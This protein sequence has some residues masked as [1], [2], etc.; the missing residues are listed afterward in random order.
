MSSSVRRASQ[1]TQL[2]AW[3]HLTWR[4]EVRRICSH[5]MIRSNCKVQLILR[6]HS[7]VIGDLQLFKCTLQ[8]FKGNAVA[9]ILRPWKWKM[10]IIK[11]GAAVFSFF[12][13]KYVW[14][15]YRGK[16]INCTVVQKSLGKTTCKLLLGA[17]FAPC[18]RYFATKSMIHLSF[19]DLWLLRCPAGGVWGAKPLVFHRLLR[20]Q[21]SC[22]RSLPGLINKCAGGWFHWP[23]KQ[24]EP[25]LPWTLIQCQPQLDNREHPQAHWQRYGLH[26]AGGGVSL[27]CCAEWC[28]SDLWILF[29]GTC[30]NHHFCFS[31]VHLY[32]VGGEVYAECL[33]DT[34]I[35]VQSRNCNY[36]HGFHPTTVCKIPSGCSLKIFNNQE[37]AQLLAQS[38]NHGFEAV[39]E[40]TKMCTIRM[41][42][43]K[44]RPWWNRRRDKNGRWR[45]IYERAFNWFKSPPGLGSWIPQTG[46]HK[47]PLLD[48]GASARAASV[49]GQGVDTNGFSS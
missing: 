25:L 40:L 18:G 2:A 34:S 33:S 13:F 22:W 24:Q 30:P 45:G 7:K 39:Y 49:V 3:C 20:T 8:H 44:V 17:I 9:E 32:Y 28:H 16:M 15:V 12:I 10:N 4:G 47:H 14:V 5:T 29:F 11:V 1:W 46:R 6:R 36:H 19:C 27:L 26:T 43:V 21:Q 42:F 35:F 37:F 48:W 23:F 31:G 41:S 38:V